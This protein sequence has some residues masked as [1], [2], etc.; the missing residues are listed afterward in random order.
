VLYYKID[1]AV[2]S[3]NL[4]V[5]SGRDQMFV[6]VKQEGR[7]TKVIEPV[8]AAII[9][10]MKDKGID[11]LIVDPFISTHEV[12]ENDN[13]KIQQ[14]AAQF[15]KIAND[16]NVAVELVHHVNKAA[17]DGKNEVTADSA[18]GASALKDK[19]RSVRTINTMSTEEA[20]KAGIDPNERFSFVR[21]SNG[22]S[23]MKKRSGHSDW[24]ELVSVNLGNG[25]WFEPEG[26]SVGVATKWVWPSTLS[27]A[28]SVTPAQLD[29]IKSAIRAGHFKADA[30][31]KAWAGNVFAKI[32]GLDVADKAS[33]A[34]INRIMTAYL[35]LGHFEV[36]KRRDDKSRE[37]KPFLRS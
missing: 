28:E 3:R 9:Q 19:A 21:V 8:V 35:D 20:K 5:D 14:V 24:S 22:K 1:A 33:K 18:R 10:E 4:F 12:D 23:N 37:L 15:V 13:S 29:E 7:G 11:V 26:D 31:A 16:A 17:G 25:D 27:L 36:N 34:L 6:V 2:L 32:L 30:Q